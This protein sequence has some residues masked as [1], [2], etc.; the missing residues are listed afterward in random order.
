LGY[1]NK[2]NPDEQ[3]AHQGSRKFLWAHDL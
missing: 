3:Q 2:R 1:P